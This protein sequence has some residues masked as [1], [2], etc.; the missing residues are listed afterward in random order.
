PN[1]FFDLARALADGATRA[2]T[3]RPAAEE[4]AALAN[5]NSA[6][7]GDWAF[8]STASTQVLDAKG[9]RMD[10]PVLTF[11]RGED[12]RTIIV[13]RGDANAATI[14]SLPSDRFTRPRRVDSAGDREVTDVGAKGG[15][16]LIGV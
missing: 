10:M 7:A 4:A 8:D 13:P 3:T 5:F 14:A 11:V 1:A 15:H 9:N 2:Y 6:F 16:F 12:L